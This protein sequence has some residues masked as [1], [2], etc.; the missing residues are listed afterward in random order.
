MTTM[1]ILAVVNQKGGVGKTTTSVNLGSALAGLGQRVLLIDMDPQ[2]NATGGLGLQPPPRPGVYEVLMQTA[3]V[4]AA[5]VPTALPG[6]DVLA[7][8][9][10][11]AGAEV[12]LVP[13][14][15]REQR[16]K[17]ALQATS[18]RWDIVL[19]DCPPSLGLLTVNALTAAHRLLVPMQCEYFAL[20]GL[21]RLLETVKLV[22]NHLNPKLELLGILLTMF[23]ARNNLCHQVAEEVTGHFGWQVFETVIPRNVR[24]SEAPSHGL[25]IDRYDPQ[26]RGTASYRDLA[27]ELVHRLAP[28]TPQ[29]S[30]PPLELDPSQVEN[31]IEP[32]R[33]A[34]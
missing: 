19:I 1:H 30:M 11:L 15:A 34:H 5:A 10:D 24:L 32:Q 16:L 23:D 21:S 18:E 33:L 25:P 8:H 28:L 17:Q 20:E 4:S 31:Q 14:I 12:E 9:P 2:A 13:A 22:Q 3:D 29:A 6:L 27:V 26:S 7:A